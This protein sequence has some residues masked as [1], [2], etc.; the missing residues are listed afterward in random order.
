MRPPFFV[1][2][3]GQ[4]HVVGR[5][6]AGGS[7]NDDSQCVAVQP[8]GVCF[9]DSGL[10]RAPDPFERA[11]TGWVS[12]TRRRAC[13]ATERARPDSSCLTDADRS[14]GFSCEEELIFGASADADGDG[15]PDRSDNCPRRRTPS[16]GTSTGTASATPA[17]CRPAETASSPT[18]SSAT[19]AAPRAETAATPACSSPPSRSRAATASM[20]TETDPSTLRTRAANRV[21]I[22][23]DRMAAAPPASGPRAVAPSAPRPRKAR[24]PART[25][26]QGRSSRPVLHDRSLPLLRPGRRRWNTRGDRRHI[27]TEPRRIRCGRD[28]PGDR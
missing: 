6:H 3:D 2:P 22:R 8:T 23:P 5:R 17:T 12:P 13:A 26:S 25:R 19:T 11:V 20:T 18:R 15:V 24:R 28:A 16:R 27:R 21:G 10:R 7:C 4:S 14:P 9:E 1:V